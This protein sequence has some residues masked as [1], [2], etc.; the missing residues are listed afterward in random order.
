MIRTLVF[1]IQYDGSNFYGWQ[2][3]IDKRTV[4]GEF[5]K[6]LKNLFGANLKAII[7][8]RT[9]TGVHA[10]NQIVTVAINED[11][12]SKIRV[13]KEKLTKVMN[14]YLP[15]DIM[16]NS[17]NYL[18]FEFNARFDA[19]SREYSYLIT[20]Q[21]NVFDYKYKYQINRFDLPKNYKIFNTIDLELL[22]EVSSIFVGKHDFTT[23]SK[24]NNDVGHYRCD[25]EFAFWEKIDDYNYIFRIKANRFV[26]S[27]VRTLVGN[28]LYL[29]TK[30]CRINIKDLQNNLL[31]MD[32][33][34][35]LGIA[36]SNGLY[37]E[38]VVYPKEFNLF[39]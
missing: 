18:D 38:N 5:E 29:N 7:S 14:N 30:N 27:M 2:S 13:P 3:Q 11:C 20:T 36:P 1:S 37:F 21:N 22:N 10:K 12:E 25:V 17:S 39:D 31:A 19:I 26:Y 35:S 33:S 9:D 15:T 24:I 28:I 34:L 23:F 8:G 6:A 16:V 32:R 4:Q